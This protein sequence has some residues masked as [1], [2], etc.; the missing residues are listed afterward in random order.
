MQEVG[1]GIHHPCPLQSHKAPEQV[2]SAFVSTVRFPEPE[3]SIA[4]DFPPSASKKR[5]KALI[6]ESINYM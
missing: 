1:W 3:Y 5:K 2:Q 6:Q 4:N